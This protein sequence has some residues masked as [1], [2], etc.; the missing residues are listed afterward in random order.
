[1]GLVA[2]AA[3]CVAGFALLFRFFERFHV[4]LL[5]A[6]TI[7]YAV[8]FACGSIIA[9]ARMASTAHPLLIGASCLGTLFVLIFFV[10]GLSAQQAGA[11]RTTIA[12]RMSLVLTITGAV[13]LFDERLD[14]L[15]SI[16]IVVA[17]VGLLLTATGPTERGSTRSAW[18]LP[19]LLF[20]CSGVA[21]ISVTYVQRTY[22]TPRTVDGFPTLCF[23]VSTVVSAVLLVIR[24]GPRALF[25]PRSWIGGIAL[26][27]VNYASLLFLVRA[28]NIDGIQASLVFPLMNILAILFATIAGL[29]VL[30]ERLSAVQWCGIG[31]CIGAMMVFLVAT[32]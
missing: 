20:V 29:V 3:L 24:D 2:L 14:L 18:G 5:P 31:C 6:I 11:V 22:T 25:Q 23:A 26:G 30:R 8:A 15:R 10:T 9:P 27:V 7:N 19:L 12:G 4:P 28:L 1:M 17:L 21:D 32:P 13:L 16:G